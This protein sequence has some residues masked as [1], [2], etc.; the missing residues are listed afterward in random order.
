MRWI[1]NSTAVATGLFWSVASAAPA[2]ARSAEQWRRDLVTLAAELPRRHPRPFHAVRESDWRAAVADLDARIP[3]LSPNQTKVGFMKLVAMIGDG[4]TVLSPL[5]GPELGFH[6]VP[7]R[8]YQ[9]SNGI[10]VRAADAEHRDLI[11]ARLTT[12]GTV[13][14][15]EAIR[16]IA[17]IVSRDNDEGLKLVVP[18]YLGIPEILDGLGLISGDGRVAYRFEKEGRVIAAELAPGA[19]VGSDVLG[20]LLPFKNP[21]GWIDARDGAANPPPLWL[22]DPTTFYR[23]SYDEKNRL[24]YIQFNIVANRPGETIAQFFG[25]IPAFARAHPVEKL[26]LD[27]RQNAGGNNQLNAPIVRAVLASGLG[28]RGRLFVVI[29]RETFSAAENLVNDLSKLASPI[30][31]GE[32][33]GA[34]PNEYGDPERV[35]LPESGLVVSVSTFFYTDAGRH[36]GTRT[37]PEVPTE[38]SFDEYRN[39]V[40]PAMDRIV[41]YRSLTAALT[42]A[43]A[44]ADSTGLDRAYRAFKSSPE[45]SWIQT[46]RETN[47]LGYSLLGE[48]KTSLAVL[49]FRLNAESYPDSVN[50]YDS[51]G[52]AWSAA[53]DVTCARESYSRLLELDPGNDT[54][55]RALAKLPSR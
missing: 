15:D 50:V 18:K 34:S 29:G 49:L 2:P 27:V 53:G 52:E 41:R 14:V 55:R 7:V 31:V 37:N 42:A 44:A 36:A 12:V 33:T 28:E 22:V 47:S 43:I 20:D 23:K 39:N 13:G 51:L 26:V 17:P 38:L 30:F 48:G 4:H 11:G 46:E 5:A 6:S 3:T 16:R 8:F 35:T 19:A 24:L 21:P 10:F 9:F 1:R 54:A 32:P 40:D 25:A 45:T